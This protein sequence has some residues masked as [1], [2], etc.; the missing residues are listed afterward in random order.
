MKCNDI[1]NLLESFITGDISPTDKETVKT[2]MESCPECKEEYQQLKDLIEGLGSVKE[3]LTLTSEERKEMRNMFSM[4]KK[5]GNWMRILQYGSWAAMIALAVFVG[6]IFMSPALAAKITPNFPLVKEILQ[7]KQENADLK[8][9]LE[10]YIQTDNGEDQEKIQ[11]MS[12]QEKFEVQNT[13]LSFVKAQYNGDKNKMLEL[14]SDEFAKIMK[15]D[16]GFVPVYDQSVKLG[17]IMITNTVKMEGKYYSFV[18]L[19]DSRRD[20]QY[21]ENFYLEK[22]N[23]KYKITMVENDV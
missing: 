21:Q 18:R 3:S 9:K 12:D 1:Q 16:P 4:G 17:V 10:V 19:E 22:M 8:D 13:V 15:N 2:H 6:S 5:S 23:G 11:E 14:A 20:T 7:L